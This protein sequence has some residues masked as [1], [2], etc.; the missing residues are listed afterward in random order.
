M[1]ETFQND[2]TRACWPAMR[3]DRSFEFCYNAQ[4]SAAAVA[5]FA[6]HDA[7]SQTTCISHEVQ[8]L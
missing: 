6:M 8:N 5:C 1:P 3:A 4:A 7:A 2:A